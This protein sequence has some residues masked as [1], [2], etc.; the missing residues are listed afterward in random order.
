MSH[1]KV[2]KFLE[3]HS[4]GVLSTVSEDGKPWGSAIYFVTDD[5]F[6]FY[7][8]TR[9]NTLQ[10][11]NMNYLPVAAITVADSDSQQTV[12][13]M[14]AI[15]RVSTSD[16][17]DIVFNKLVKIRPHSDYSWVP[18]VDKL[19]G[20]DYMVLRLTPEKLQYADYKEPKSDEHREYIE[21]II[22]A[23]KD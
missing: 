8:V 20:G 16:M 18:P 1:D 22:P 9:V 2:R 14:G 17:V 19:H 21:T 5:D 6:N 13:V 11:Q 3:K 15:S 4:M 23:Q 12:Q 10:H 7:F